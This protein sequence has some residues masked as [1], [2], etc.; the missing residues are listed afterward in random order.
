MSPNAH[1]SLFYR[2]VTVEADTYQSTDLDS[3]GINARASGGNIT[4]IDSTGF[5]P[6]A[7]N[8]AD[9]GGAWIPVKRTLYEDS[10]RTTK[11][12]ATKQP[13]LPPAGPLSLTNTELLEVMFSLGLPWIAFALYR[14][15]HERKILDNPIR[16]EMLALIKKNP[17]ISV[18]DTARLLNVDFKTALHHSRVLADYGHVELARK[19]RFI[20]L[21][22]NH[23]SFGVNEKGYILAFD[24]E[25]RRKIAKLVL[26]EPGITQAEMRG[27]LAF[28]KSTVN[29]HVSRLASS[30]I[31]QA[32][33]ERPAG[34]VVGSEIRNKVIDALMT[35]TEGSIIV[36]T[37][38][39][40][41]GSSPS[42]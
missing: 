22:E 40:L 18:S 27:R 17:G 5:A 1:V 41:S 39:I 7:A 26:L 33:P 31:V 19:G 28:A 37:T 12:Y 8:V 32:H 34:Y 36:P 4:E 21:F 29:F 13:T 15:L 25:V 24:S 9:L 10:P 2:R 3:G 16:Q 30:G 20:R 11:S 35:A 14:R 23:N 42:A 6:R 38:S